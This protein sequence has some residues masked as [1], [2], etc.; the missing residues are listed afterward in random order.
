MVGGGSFIGPALGSSCRQA[1]PPVTVRRQANDAMVYWLHVT[2]TF[3]MRFVPVGIAYRLVGAL[4]PAFMEL[5]ARGYLRRATDNMRQVLGPQASGR[6]ARR[7]TKAAFANYARYMVDL[8]RMP[9][10]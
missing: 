9:N 1:R 4:T 3:L 10:L 8:V 7:V 6:E 2:G 5:F